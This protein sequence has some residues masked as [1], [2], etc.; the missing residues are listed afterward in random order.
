MVA[1]SPFQVDIIKRMDQ[2]PERRRS[3]C[4]SVIRLLKSRVRELP[5]GSR[6]RSIFLELVTLHVA[7][8][9]GDC[10]QWDL[11]EKTVEHLCSPRNLCVTWGMG[12]AGERPVVLIPSP[13]G[14]WNIYEP[15]RCGPRFV[16]LMTLI[17]DDYLRIIPD[18]H[19]EFEEGR[20]RKLHVI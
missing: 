5:F 2:L 17:R 20:M 12:A 18:D 15:A 10:N 4:K 1:S 3:H 6:P 7:L 11:L 16:A 8:T 9:L 14:R 13:L 19:L